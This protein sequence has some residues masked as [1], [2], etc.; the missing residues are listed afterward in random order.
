[1]FWQKKWVWEGPKRRFLDDLDPKRDLSGAFPGF[2]TGV[3]LFAR[4]LQ[5]LFQVV[6]HGCQVHAFVGL[7]DAEGVHF[8]KPHK[9]L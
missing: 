6:G 1:M 3:R 9:L 4:V 8:P 5:E 7:A 2:C